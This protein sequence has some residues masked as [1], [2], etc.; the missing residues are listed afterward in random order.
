M[1]EQNMSEKRKS[2]I[3]ERQDHERHQG[4]E[5]LSREIAKKAFNDYLRSI[6]ERDK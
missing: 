5:Q 1:S 4:P 2:S 6:E 3:L